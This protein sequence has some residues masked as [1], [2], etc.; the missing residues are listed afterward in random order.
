ML[1]SLALPFSAHQLRDAVRSARR[2][3]AAGLDRV[4][5]LDSERGVVETQSSASWAAVSDYLLP[6]VP[7]LKDAWQSKRSVGESVALNS[8]GPDGRPVVAHVESM[9][10]VTPDGELRRVNRESHPE[11]FA[12]AVGGQGLFGAPYSVTLR[13][14]SLARAAVEAAPSVRLDLEQEPAGEDAR[15]LQLFVAPGSVEPF[16]AEARALCSEWH[17]HI[18]AIE[19]RPTFQ[20]DETVLRWARRDY[21]Q[22][23]LVLSQRRSL[24]G[25]VRT[26]QLCR[27]LIDAAISHGGGFPISCTPEAT[28]QQV[29]ACYPELRRVLAEKRRLDPCGKLDNPWF[30]HH[31]SLL[32]REACK[33]R[34]N[35]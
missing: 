6:T 30:R 28:R 7:E 3:N 21:A 33:V 4:L 31:A 12:L 20:E 2:F 9:A 17:T 19:V 24:G 11:I 23:N 35:A 16:M 15:A 26:T 25:A 14:A 5:R 13:L 32:G 34:W 8:T 29:E 27:Q 18:G 1:D 10:L 22:M